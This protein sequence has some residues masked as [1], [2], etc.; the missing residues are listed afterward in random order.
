L[1]VCFPARLTAVSNVEGLMLFLLNKI[2]ARIDYQITR[3]A[4]QTLGAFV[5]KN[6]KYVAFI[7]SKGI[8][9]TCKTLAYAAQHYYLLPMIWTLCKSSGT[10]LTHF[11]ATR[12]A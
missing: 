4:A 9:N 6:K 3:D 11:S 2:E 1:F 8:I 12:M 7:L 5:P 10:L